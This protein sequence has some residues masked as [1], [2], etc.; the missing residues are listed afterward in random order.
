MGICL[1]GEKMKSSNMYYITGVLCL[2]A[3]LHGVFTGADEAVST[4][5][6]IIT[7]WF[8]VMAEIK[9]IKGK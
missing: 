6:L 3:Y 2:I 4:R 1:N 7:A 5:L 9:D 8:S